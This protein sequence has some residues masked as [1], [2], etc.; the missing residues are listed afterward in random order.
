MACSTLKPHKDTRVVDR[1]IRGGLTNVQD[2]L[3]GSVLVGVPVFPILQLLVSA[4]VFPKDN[5]DNS[6]RRKKDGE[7]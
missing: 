6:L 4:L 5:H 7:R 1:P 3:F 2:S